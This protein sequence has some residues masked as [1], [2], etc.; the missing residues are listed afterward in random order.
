MIAHDLKHV[1][2]H[3]SSAKWSYWRSNRWA[4]CKILR[5]L[6]WSACPFTVRRTSS[7]QVASIRIA[8][9]A[10]CNNARATKYLNGSL[11][12]RPLNRSAS[13]LSHTSKACSM[14]NSRRKSTSSQRNEKNK[15]SASSSTS[16]LDRAGSIRWT[17]IPN[18]SNCF[19]IP[20]PF[21]KKLSFCS[22]N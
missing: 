2:I 20:W 14:L 1:I 8:S 6:C 19:W 17:S 4:C 5:T 22:T 7:K 18:A 11:P 21:G 3:Y 15:W 16:R 12:S 13:K 9:R 10:S